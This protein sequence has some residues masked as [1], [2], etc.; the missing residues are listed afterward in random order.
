MSLLLP[1]PS[2]LILLPPSLLTA[3]T[4]FSSIIFANKDERCL[5]APFKVSVVSRDAKKFC[6][7]VP[8]PISFLLLLLSMLLFVV[9]VRPSSLPSDEDDTIANNAVVVVEVDL[10]LVEAEPSEYFS[11]KLLLLLEGNAFVYSL[12]CDTTRVDD[13]NADGDE[14]GDGTAAASCEIDSNPSNVLVLGAAEIEERVGISSCG[15]KASP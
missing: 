6:L 9:A 4:L 5:V 3:T 10:G 2:S 11:S 7:L 13:N 12:F 1:L 8:V 15:A 14:A